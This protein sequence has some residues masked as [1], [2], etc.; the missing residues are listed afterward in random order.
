MQT[1]HS[2]HSHP[3]ARMINHAKENTGTTRTHMKQRSAKATVNPIHA[4]NEACEQRPKH[5]DH[6]N[7]P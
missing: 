4:Q 2:D 5:S 6:A 7:Q 3:T 1:P